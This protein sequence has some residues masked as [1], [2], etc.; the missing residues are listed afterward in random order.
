MITVFSQSVRIQKERCVYIQKWWWRHYSSPHNKTCKEL[1]KIMK[2]IMTTWRVIKIHWNI[3][4]FTIIG[5]FTFVVFFGVSPVLAVKIHLL[6]GGL[7]N[8]NW[9]L[10]L[11]NAVQ[12]CKGLSPRICLSFYD[13][14]TLDTR[15]HLFIFDALQ[16]NWDY[17]IIFCR[18]KRLC[19]GISKTSIS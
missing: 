4:H 11:I 17:V 18:I 7:H 10:V 15:H 1:I 13:S 6:V 12:V 19:C 8:R 3:H 5:A 14:L 2:I 9:F 16:R